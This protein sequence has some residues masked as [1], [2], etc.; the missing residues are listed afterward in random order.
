MNQTIID[1]IGD[2]L[3]YWANYIWT[4]KRDKIINESAIKYG[5]SEYLV[6]S[7][8]MNSNRPLIGQPA[9]TNV[10]FEDR[11][12]VFKGRRTD[13]LFEVYED[14]KNVKIYFEFKYLRSLPL[15]QNE[16]NRYINDFF[17]LT[18]L[19]KLNN[20]NECFFLLMGSPN[21]VFNLLW[22]NG[23]NR[24][25]I[26]DVPQ[27]DYKTIKQCLSLSKDNPCVF[28]LQDLYAN[29]VPHLERFRKDYLYRENINEQQKLNENDKIEIILKYATPLEGNENIGVYIWQINID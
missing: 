1:G 27:Y 22:P 16:I 11:H 29:E 7:E 26:K 20:V 13:L 24:T 14:N 6:A 18:A 17:R 4:V 23:N 25:I 3:K 21:N 19:A 10:L 8:S 15:Q 5:I 9:I 28:H 12:D 2:S